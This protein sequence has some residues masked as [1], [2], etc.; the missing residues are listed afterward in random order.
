MPLKTGRMRRR[1]HLSGGLWTGAQSC[2][3]VAARLPNPAI[4]REERRGEDMRLLSR[5]KLVGPGAF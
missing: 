3:A 4:G 5:H 2:A 1:R